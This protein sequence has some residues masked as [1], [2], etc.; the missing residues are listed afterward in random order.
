MRNYTENEFSIKLMI[1]L[2]EKTLDECLDM[3]SKF[4]AEPN[5]LD[6]DT[7]EIIFTELKIAIKNK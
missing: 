1:M 5:L 6:K 7:M 4:N 3:Q 2:R